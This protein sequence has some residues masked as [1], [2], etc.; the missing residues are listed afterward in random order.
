MTVSVLSSIPG[1]AAGQIIQATF[2]MLNDPG[3]ISVVGLKSGDTI[4]SMITTSQPRNAN[5]VGDGHFEPIISVDDEIQ[6]YA[7]FAGPSP[8]SFVALLYR[9]L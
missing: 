7:S 9:S 2:Q 3:T 8:T 1:A 4:L 6:Q 5:V